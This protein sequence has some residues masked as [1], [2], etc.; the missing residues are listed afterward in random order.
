MPNGDLFHVEF[1]RSTW[2]TLWAGAWFHFLVLRLV[3]RTEDEAAFD[4]VVLD[5]T[6]LR[7]HASAACHHATCTYQLIQVQ[8]P[9]NR[10]NTWFLHQNSYKIQYFS[11][12]NSKPIQ[13]P[14]ILSHTWFS[15]F[16]KERIAWNT[17]MHAC[18][19]YLARIHP[20]DVYLV[21]DKFQNF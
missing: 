8:L 15:V 11:S 19:Y 18:K 20:S 13:G 6:K 10:Y 5:D 9:D 3:E 12:N 1:K 14:S 16:K 4:A 7:H 21:I 17:W 2:L